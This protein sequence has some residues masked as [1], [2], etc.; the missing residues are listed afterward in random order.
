MYLL[1]LWIAKALQYTSRLFGNG[2][3]ALPG[4]FVESFSKKFLIKFLGKLPE[5]VIVVS[6]TN[7]KTTTTKIIADSL[8]LLGDRVMTN[9][10]G[11]NM[12][13]GLISTVVSKATLAGRLP[14]DIAILE[15]DEAYASVISQYLPINGA[16]VL[17]VMRDQLDRFGEIDKTASLLESL[18]KKAKNFVVIN[19]CDSRVSNLKYNKSSKRITFGI[20]EALTTKF[21][22]EDNWHNQLTSKV[23]SSDYTLT[24]TTENGLT[25]VFQKNKYRINPKLK[26]VHNHLN[27]VASVAVLD[28][29]KKELNIES[30]LKLTESITPAFGRGEVINLGKSQITLFLIKNPSSF[31]QTAST[32]KL[33]DYDTVSIVINDAYADSRDVSWLWDVDMS[34]FKY[35]KEIIAG[36]VRAYDVA[37]RLKHEDLRVSD[38]IL[39]EK[40]LIKLLA[41][42]SQ[43]HAVFCSYTAMLN[44]RKTLVKKAGLER[45]I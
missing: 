9:S 13:R 40:V 37:V 22:N 5:G 45:V 43:K 10:S 36:G 7:G 6:G 38:I 1:I 4:L 25:M 26:G 8:T 23:K 17:N 3:A 27:L 44:L 35:A 11:S 41:K 33:D 21:R 32:V 20:S 18:T 19:S 2:G 42:R 34:D 29:I 12:T 28:Q 39:N 16:V 24:E 15:V 30:K 14:Y 31:I